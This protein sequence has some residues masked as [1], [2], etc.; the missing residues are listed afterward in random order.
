MR[1]SLEVCV[2]VCVW[3][4]SNKTIQRHC[5][6]GDIRRIT[7]TKQLRENP[8]TSDTNRLLKLATFVLT[9]IIRADDQVMRLSGV[10]LRRFSAV[11]TNP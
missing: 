9:R 2:C 6:N 4:S 7:V 5:S 10:F 1:C 11:R 8:F 3:R